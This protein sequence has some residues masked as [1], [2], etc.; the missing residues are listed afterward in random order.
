MIKLS[1]GRDDLLRYRFAISPLWETA[2]AVRTLL[3][4][5]RHVLH[6]SWLRGVARRLGRLD[7]GPLPV[8]MPLHGYTP[9]F[10][11]PPPSTPLASIEEELERVRQ[12]PPDRL[13]A[14]VGRA[15][16]QLND[17]SRLRE[18]LADPARVA[19]LLADRLHDCWQHLLAEDW[20]RIRDML[21]ADVLYWAR[22]LTVGGI[23]TL[24]DDLHPDVSW[25]PGVITV[26]GPANDARTLDGLG[27]LLVPSAFTWPTVSVLT[28][29]PWQPTLIYPARGVARLWEQ[30]AATPV[31]LEA[32]VGRG[33][34]AVL[35]GLE[36]PSSTAT[37][38]R[39]IGL[40]P[41][42]VSRHLAILRNAGLTRAY[43]SGHEVIY[44]QTPL[45]HA[46]T[47]QDD[48]GMS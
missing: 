34:A 42:T 39:R 10:L 2:A 37:L 17:P 4:P 18:L 32:L 29:H 12:T 24:L 11:T 15:V 8:L 16:A 14:E 41:G 22:R 31:H 20:P 45:G 38:A 27:L 21:E 43:R 36:Q 5:S 19:S 3:D 35:V 26:A 23:Q 7:L 30:T 47:I 48:P 6:L 40:S 46:L 33:R 28:D 44:E 25:R 13:R 9:D 1:Y